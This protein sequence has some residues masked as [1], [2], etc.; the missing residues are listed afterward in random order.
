[1]KNY[2]G[3]VLGV[4]SGCAGLLLAQQFTKSGADA[5][6]AEPES[7]SSLVVK[8][9]E[10]Q[11][12]DARKRITELE[13]EVAEA[14]AVATAEVA[15]AGDAGIESSEEADAKGSELGSFL[16][17]MASMGDSG[18]KRKIE[19]EVDRLAAVLGLSENQQTVLHDALSKK[20]ADQKAAGLKLLTGKATLDDLL[21]SDENNFVA[22]DA[23]LME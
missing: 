6:P 2:L 4:V 12:A 8:R 18:E 17:L 19:K 16:E 15:P 23:A 21:A 5:N 3:F 7:G 10:K 9:Q 13:E 20:A 1:M 14:K 22:V 11:L